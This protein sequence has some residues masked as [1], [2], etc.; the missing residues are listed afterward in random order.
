MAEKFSC[1]REG[2]GH[3]HVKTI[4]VFPLLFPALG[5]VDRKVI[6]TLSFCVKENVTLV[7]KIYI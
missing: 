6:P 1:A 5:Q 2:G 3:V 7:K 4:Q